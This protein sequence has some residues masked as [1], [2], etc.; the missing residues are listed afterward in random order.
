M[1]IAPKKLGLKGKR[2]R[3]I[4]RDNCDHAWEKAFSRSS[5][6]ILSV[7]AARHANVAEMSERLGIEQH[8]MQLNIGG[9]LMRSFRLVASW[10]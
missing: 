9:L 10:S 1:V 4:N 3:I 7:D 6:E 2:D 8:L 5:F